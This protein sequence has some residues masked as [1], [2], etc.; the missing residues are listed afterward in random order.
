METVLHGLRSILAVFSYSHAFA[1]YRALRH[2]RPGAMARDR[3][4]WA[5]AMVTLLA[6]AALVVLGM[7]RP[8]AAWEPHRQ[9]AVA[10]G[11]APGGIA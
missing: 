7:V 11:A 3:A 4:A 9:G 6:S 10:V 8:S 2:R 5:M 1:G